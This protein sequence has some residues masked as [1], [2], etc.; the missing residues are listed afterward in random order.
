MP[1]VDSSTFTLQDEYTFAT[2]PSFYG[3]TWEDEPGAPLHNFHF[4]TEIRFWFEYRAGTDQVLEFTGD[5]D[6]W[7]FVNRQLAMDL[8]GIHLP[9][10]GS[11]RL[12]AVAAA[13]GLD[14]GL[15]Y[16]IAIFQ[17]ERQTS[18]SSFRLTLGGFNVNPSRCTPL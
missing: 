17:A 6:M 9:V 3:G 14:D 16:E 15:V 8:G 4:T 5:D 18:G 1:P 7:V 2:V 11:V 12:D 13:A 10:A